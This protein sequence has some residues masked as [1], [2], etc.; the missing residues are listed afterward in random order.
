MSF[1]FL[2]FG[3]SPPYQQI[4]DYNGTTNGTPIYIGWATTGVATSYAGWRI[5]KFTY[6]ASNQLLQIQFAAG[7]VGFNAIWDDR[8]SLTYK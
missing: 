4:F 2:D 6:D 7:D 5:R 3:S 8:A 1:P